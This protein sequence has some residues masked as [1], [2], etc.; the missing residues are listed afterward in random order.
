MK[1]LHH[2]PSTGVFADMD[3]N[4]KEEV[5]DEEAQQAKQGYNLHRNAASA[6]SLCR[7]SVL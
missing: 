5:G 3:D 6:A 1:C 2:D 7:Q 4:S